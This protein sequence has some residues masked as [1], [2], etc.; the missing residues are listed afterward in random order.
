MFD[1][2]RDTFMRGRDF[3]LGIILCA[4]LGP[5]CAD[6]IHIYLKYDLDIYRTCVVGNLIIPLITLIIIFMY[7]IVV[8]CIAKFRPTEIHNEHSYMTV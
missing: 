3:L 6:F 7:I 4:I 5:Y 2:T 1:T 8:I